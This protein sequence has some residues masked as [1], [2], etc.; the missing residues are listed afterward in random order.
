[1]GRS[2]RW[3]LILSGAAAILTALGLAAL[4]L[5]LL[6]ERHVERVAVAD[7]SARALTLAAMVE[8][9]GARLGDPPAD[10]LYDQPFSGHYWQVQLGDDLRRS[11]S[12]WDFRLPMAELSPGATLVQTLAGPQGEALLAVEQALK[13]GDQTFRILVATDRDELTQARQ[14]FLGDLLPYLALLG[15]LL[16]LA[17]GLQVTIGLRPL[18]NV[19]TRVAALNAGQRDRMGGDLPTEVIPLAQEIDTLLDARDT[20][21]ARA[22]H[23]A[24]DLAHG[25]KTPLQ[26]LLGDAGLLRDRGQDDLAD[27]VEH[28]ASSMR[29]LVDR[30]LARARIGSDRGRAEADVARAVRRVIEVLRRTPKGGDI[31]WQVQGAEGLKARIDPDDLTEALGALLENALRHAAGQVAVTALATPGGIVLTIRDDGPGVAPAD[32][33]RLSERGLRLDESGEGQGIGLAIVADIVEAA[34]G[35]LHFENGGPGLVVTIR[36][37]AAIA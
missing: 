30:E 36:L 18:A 35:A 13:V 6:F 15:G 24:G 31:Q 21:L 34:R 9:D 8:D 16:V 37:R 5:A 17:S 2:L 19:S 20:E 3:R 12:L 11:R 28:V 10:P 26:A 7:L 32:L 29:R 25:F 4:G 22:R 14:G 27:S 33:A 1:M 23:R